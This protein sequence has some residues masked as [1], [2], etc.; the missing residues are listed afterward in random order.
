MQIFQ[1]LEILD[2]SQNQ[3]RGK[4]P[5]FHPLLSL[6]VL[7]VGNNLLDGSI[8]P[9]LFGSS[10]QL[11][12][13]DLSSNGFSVTDGRHP[14]ATLDRNGLRPSRFYITHSGHVIMA[15]EVG[16]GDILP[17]DVARKGRHVI[18]PKGPY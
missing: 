9:E 10:M 5:S 6:R 16:V 12:E 1:N 8:P 17:K 14:V 13:L 3:I 15:S 4:L 11:E 2:V 7:W 18:G